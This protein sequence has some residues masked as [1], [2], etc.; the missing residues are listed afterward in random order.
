MRR[1][2]VRATSWRPWM[3]SVGLALVLCHCGGGE[4]STSPED[5]KASPSSCA[6]PKSQGVSEPCCMAHGVDA[7]GGGLFCEAFDGRTQPTCYV[8]GSRLDLAECSADAQC[9]SQSC[10]TDMNQCRSVLGARCESDVGC[11]S[12]LVNKYVA[13]TAGTCVAGSTGPTMGSRPGS[14]STG[15]SSS[16][17]CSRGRPCIAGTCQAGT[18]GSLCDEDSHCLSMP[19]ISGECSSGAEGSRCVLDS[20]CRDDVQYCAIGRCSYGRLGDDC[21]ST[22]DC[23]PPLTCTAQFCSSD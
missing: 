21:Q 7:C 23:S 15:C 5:S 22:D 9:A 13:C 3:L 2:P 1:G 17:E 19:C 20:D 18:N 6:E 4:E 14:A 11:S 10:N 16:A 8:E 12:V